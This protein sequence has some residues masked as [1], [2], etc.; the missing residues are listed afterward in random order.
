[1]ASPSNFSFGHGSGNINYQPKEP[2]EST[3]EK[4]DTGSRE[5][6]TEKIDQA[7]KSSMETPIE[8]SDKPKK[9]V[10]HSGDKTSSSSGEKVL[11]GF[12]VVAAAPMLAVGAVKGVAKE[13]FKN[14]ETEIKEAQGKGIKEAQSRGT[15]DSKEKK[16]DTQDFKEKKVKDVD[17]L[18]RKRRTIEIRENSSSSPHSSSSPKSS[19]KRRTIDFKRGKSEKDLQAQ[20]RKMQLEEKHAEKLAEQLEMRNAYQ[21]ITENPQHMKEF[22]ANNSHSDLIILEAEG[23]SGTRGQINAA[24]EVARAFLQ[25]K[26]LIEKEVKI[27]PHNNNRGK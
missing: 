16:V 5:E 2:V 9:V 27:S 26:G 17:G 6:K 15:Q 7:K 14:K 11:K 12:Y 22:L 3:K 23:E 20:F 4:I 10:N 19:E 8:T 21:T 18:E 13:A 25:S 1:M 24:K